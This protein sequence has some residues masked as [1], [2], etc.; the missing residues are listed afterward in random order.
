MT[1]PAAATSYDEVPYPNQAHSQTHPDRLAAMATLLGMQ[2]APPARCRVLELGC[3]AGANL[4]PMAYAL[5]GSE[6]LGID[7]S[8]RQVADGQAL[9]EALGLKNIELRHQDLLTAGADLGRFDYIIAHGLYAWVPPNVQDRVL[10]LCGGHLD[11]QGVAFVSYDAYPYGHLR[12]VA[13]DMM[14]YHSRG[15]A[16]P[17]DRAARARELLTLLREAEPPEPRAYHLLLRAEHDRYAVRSDEYLLHECLGDVTEPLLFRDFADRAARH[18]LRYLTEVYYAA[19]T[20]TRF[21]PRVVR[22]LERLNVLER[23]QYLDF[24]NGRAFRQTLLCRQD[25]GDLPGLS[26]ERLTSFYLAATPVLDDEA[27]S[28]AAA[29]WRAGSPLAEAALGFLREVRPRW[30][31]FEELHGAARARL[32]GDAVLVQSAAEHGRERQTLAESLLRALA[33]G[34]VELHASAPGFISEVRERP[35]ASAVARAQVARGN[36]TVTALDHEDV[37]LAPEGAQLLFY[38]DGRHDRAALVE[39][40]VRFVEVNDLAV[41]RDGRAVTDPAEVRAVLAGDVDAMLGAMA[42]RALLAG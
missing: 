8:A 35:L 9:V 12:A 34:A 1:N 5:P 7:L 16:D 18:G 21:P 33:A 26:P 25:V 17:V 4:I 2:P 30:V 39:A 22:Y 19:T 27:G 15:V 32:D 28:P 14:R 42:A 40:L 23:E 3:A 11:P 29:A 24:L 38:L 37:G 36:S 6:F 13:R 20:L 10:A 31:G 41:Q